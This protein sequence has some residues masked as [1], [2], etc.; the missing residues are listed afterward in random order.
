MLRRE[1]VCQATQNKYSFT[2]VN[3]HKTRFILIIKMRQLCVQQFA[4][5]VN[6]LSY[7]SLIINSTI[8]L[9]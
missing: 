5:L 7:T 8:V 2:Y 3:M 1:C 6:S 4:M 9:A